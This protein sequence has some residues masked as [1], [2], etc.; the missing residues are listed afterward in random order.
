MILHAITALTAAELTPRLAA[1]TRPVVEDWK[2]PSCGYCKDWGTHLQANRF[3]V[4]VSDAGHTEA[5]ARLGIAFALGSC[6]T[7]QAGGYAIKGHAT[8]TGIRQLLNEKP[9]TVGLAVPGM[10]TGS[11]GMDSSLYGTHKNA[12]QVMPVLQGGST[13]VLNAYPST[14]PTPSTASKKEIS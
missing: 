3:N 13:R 2:D 1:Q 5:R 10:P 9:K 4:K 8:A 11:P 6:H 14:S 7:A 12:H